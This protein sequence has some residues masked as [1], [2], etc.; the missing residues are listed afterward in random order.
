MQTSLHSQAT[1]AKF[2]PTGRFVGAGS[3]DGSARIWD[4]DTKSTVRWLEG[5]VKG[6]TTMECVVLFDAG[7]DLADTSRVLSFS[8]NARYVLT[9]SKD[10]NVSVWDLASDTDPPKRKAMIRFDAPVVSAYFHPRNRCAVLVFVHIRRLTIRA[11]GSQPNHSC[12]PGSGR[13]VHS[14]SPETAP[15]A[16]R[17]V[18]ATRWKRQR[19]RWSKPKVRHGGHPVVCSALGY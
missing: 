8:R 19:R 3:N 5:H 11:L 13:S 17:A 6:V 12:R 18:R 9:G 4:L 10:W 15:R 16:R 14:R 1:F 2:D 7:I